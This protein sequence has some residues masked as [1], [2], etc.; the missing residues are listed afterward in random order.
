MDIADETG[1]DGD[2]IRAAIADEQLRD[3]LQ[4]QFTKAQQDGV[5]GVP[6]FVYDGYSARGSVPPTQLERLVEGT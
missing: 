4:E 2:E 3:R 1:L 6:T 5:T